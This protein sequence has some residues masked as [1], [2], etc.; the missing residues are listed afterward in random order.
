MGEGDP[1][2]KYEC[3]RGW[4]AEHSC[5]YGWTS[6]HDDPRGLP[7]ALEARLIVVE[8]GW[9]PGDSSPLL[10]VRKVLEVLE[11]TPERVVVRDTKP[12]WDKSAGEY[13]D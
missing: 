2:A 9:R 6:V 10:V 5:E 4:Y 7:E 12:P 1:V 8:E 13:L 3:L 11:R